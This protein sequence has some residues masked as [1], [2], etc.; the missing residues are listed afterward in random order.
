MRV[1]VLYRPTCIFSAH[2][3]ELC[4]SAAKCPISWLRAS[5]KKWA[6]K[7]KPCEKKKTREIQW[8][9]DDRFSSRLPRPIRRRRRRLLLIF[10]FETAQ[11]YSAMQF[12]KKKERK[13]VCSALRREGEE[14]EEEGEKKH[15]KS[16][17]FLPG[18]RLIDHRQGR[19]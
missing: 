19:H 17:E 4:K 1:D 5:R 2:I 14:E 9:G 16:N 3:P 12:P 6:K 15:S 10:W 13:K 11:C 18:R 8:R 7:M